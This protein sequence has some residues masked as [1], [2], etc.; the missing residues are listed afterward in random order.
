MKRIS[1]YRKLMVVAGCVA[2]I[3]ASNV[4]VSFAVDTNVATVVASGTVVKPITV[5]GTALKFGSFMSGASLGTVT[6]LATDTAK[7]AATGGAINSTKMAAGS[8]A[9]VFTVSADDSATYKVETPVVAPLAWVVAQ[10]TKP[11]TGADDM[12]F[13]A[14]APA[15]LTGTLGQTAGGTQTFYIGGALTVAINQAAG[16]YEGCYVLPSA[17]ENKPVC[18]AYGQCLV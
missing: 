16:A 17:I 2:L 18:P 6:V 11:G 7:A 15:V 3:C 9:A 5:A 13:V 1:I 14:S 8:G 12:V 10:G 4:G